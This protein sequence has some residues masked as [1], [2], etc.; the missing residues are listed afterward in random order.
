LDKLRGDPDATRI[1]IG[2]VRSRELENL[3]TA[4][5]TA[6]RAIPERLRPSA[7]LYTL[8]LS[9]QNPLKFFAKLPAWTW[10]QSETSSGDLFN[11]E[12]DRSDSW[13][14][15]LRN[16]E[17]IALHL[18]IFSREGLPS[19]AAPLAEAF[20]RTA[21]LASLDAASRAERLPFYFMPPGAQRL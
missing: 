4:T 5:E 11:L 19:L 6:L 10:V 18:R 2:P 12:F 17:D 1:G 14:S 13:T 15:F 3:N 21:E 9:P 16:P 7:N 20:F 8:A